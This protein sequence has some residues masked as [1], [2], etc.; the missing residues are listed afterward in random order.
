[1]LSFEVEMFEMSELKLIHPFYVEDERGFFLKNYESDIFKQLNVNGK[2]NETFETYSKKNVVRGM[3]FQINNPQAKLIRAVSGIIQDVAIDLRRN[4]P[5]FG[6]WKSVILSENNHDIFFVP[7][8]FAH[9]FKVL[10]ESA[11]VSYQCIGAYDKETDT[12][13]YWN[14]KEISILWENGTEDVFVSNKDRNLM[15]FEKF[16]EVYGGLLP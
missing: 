5:T 2:I 13:I 16:C 4:S 14:D 10:S 11:L 15:S 6:K 1:M 3:H 12:G 7:Q 9:G 8:G